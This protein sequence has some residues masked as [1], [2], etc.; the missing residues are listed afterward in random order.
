MDDQTAILEY[1]L[2]WQEVISLHPLHLSRFPLTHGSQHARVI[3]SW[4]SVICGRYM[5]DQTAILEY[6]LPWQEV[7]S[8]LHDVVKNASAGY[9]SLNYSEAGYQAD[10]LVKVEM[11]LNGQY[12]S[13]RLRWRLRI[14]IMCQDP[15]STAT[16]PGPGAAR[17]PSHSPTHLSGEK[18]I[19]IVSAGEPVDAMSFVCHRDKAESTGRKIA[20][21]LKDV[22]DRQQFDITIQVC[23]RYPVSQAMYVRPSQLGN[24]CET[25]SMR[26]IRKIALKLKDGDRPTAV[27]HHHPGMDVKTHPVSHLSAVMCIFELKSIGIYVRP[28]Q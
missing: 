27:R 3:F 5:D 23:M 16:R 17:S 20:L 15:D 10:H 11:A 6:R 14:G 8:D 13:S 18:I 28:S 12:D 19:C 9:A 24:L 21:K 2:P 7:I 1:R 4:P 22:I 25:K 26:P